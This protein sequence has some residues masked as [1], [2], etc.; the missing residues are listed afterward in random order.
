MLCS[1]SMSRDV[2]IARQAVERFHQQVS[3]GQYDAIYDA[4]DP[5]YKQSLTR[6][7]NR[8]FFSRIRLK[9]GAFQNAKNTGYF[10]NTATKGTFVR[11]RYKTLCCNGELDEQFI[12]RIEG[13]RATLVRYEASSAD[14]RL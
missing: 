2:E 8:N 6:E 10:V 1:C 13:N 7:A 5:A 3:A 12:L 4:A 14:L 9:T 11:L